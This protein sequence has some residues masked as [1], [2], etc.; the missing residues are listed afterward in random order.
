MFGIH[1]TN[2]YLCN[3][4]TKDVKQTIERG[5]E[6]KFINKFKYYDYEY[7]PH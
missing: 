5:T 4:R 3:A 7:P 6:F 1:K 2:Q